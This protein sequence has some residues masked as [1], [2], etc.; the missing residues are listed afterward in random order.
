MKV[1]DKKITYLEELSASL[2]KAQDIAN[3]L[4]DN[5]L[6]KE[7]DLDRQAFLDLEGELDG[8]IMEC[9]DMLKKLRDLLKT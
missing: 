3:K 4:L 9:D 7:G 2:S 6:D 5:W 1:K 8:G